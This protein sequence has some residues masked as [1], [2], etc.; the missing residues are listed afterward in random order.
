MLTSRAKREREIERDPST[1]SDRL[2][3]FLVKYR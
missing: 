3:M 1:E 2:L